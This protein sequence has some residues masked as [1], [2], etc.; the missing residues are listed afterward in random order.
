[1]I[2]VAYPIDLG[3]SMDADLDTLATALYV[4]I[5]DALK[6]DPSLVRW[7]PEVGIAPKL[8]DAEL[9]CLAVL[10]ALL[11]FTS[12]TRWLRYATTHLVGMFPYVPGQSGYNKRLR[13]ASTQ[14]VAINRILAM[15]TDVWAD[16]T[17]VIDSTPVECG[18]SRQTAKRSD[19]VGFAGY[20]YCASHS[21]WFWGLRLHLICTPTGLPVTYALTSPK[22]DEREVAR[23]LLESEPELLA[24]RPSQ[25]LI[26]DK[27]YISAELERFLN[28]HGVDL[29]RP[30]RR[31]EPRRPGE[32]FFKPLRQLIESVN[33][34]LKGQLDLERHGGHT[35]DGVITRVAQR[36]LALTA[37]IWHNHHTGQPRLRSLIAYDH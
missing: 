13:K 30:A 29:L 2:G 20:G 1:M 16:D 28:H 25:T 6:T 7:R 9:I 24:Q 19:L 34:T 37:A 10:Q 27:G 5:D 17:W 36:V 21:R 12:E 11:G 15:D 31:G 8:S 26:A 14:L 22:V 3:G 33:D 23:D 35:I 18:R 4:K 32:R